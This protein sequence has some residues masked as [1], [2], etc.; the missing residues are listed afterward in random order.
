MYIT[1]NPNIAQIADDA[2]VD[3]VWID[4]EYKDKEIRQKG[5]NS[6]KSHHQVSDISL[7]KPLLKKAKMQVR[8][9][10]MGDYSKKQ[11]DAVISAGA[12]Y[13]MLP[14]YKT[15]QEVR[16]F[17]KYVEGRAITILLL[18][19][20]E[21][22][23]ILDETLVIPGIDEIH[24]GLN[25]L[26][27][28]FHQD[29]MFEPVANGMVDEICMKIKA[30]GKPYGF[31]GIARLGEGL[32]PAEMVISEHYR[33]GST[34]AILSRSFCM[35]EPDQSLEEISINFH[36]DLA[37]IREYEKLMSTRECSAFKKN[38][39]I[40]KESVFVVAD[41]ARARKAVQH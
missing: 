1:N 40:F 31:G 25:D 15:I 26:H 38:H 9:D 3:R 39:E 32:I 14:Y 11:I 16:N 33:V 20:K 30:A 13:I 37:D 28:S 12:E 29:F 27:L 35:P 10:H 4:L 34:R 21:A 24:I 41:K 19:T 22:I 36:K 6:V 7:I 2:G 23:D 18:E 5:L 8:I 17:A